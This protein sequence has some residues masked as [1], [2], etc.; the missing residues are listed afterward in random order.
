MSNDTSARQ[1][2]E[3][4]VLAMVILTCTNGFTTSGLT[5]YDSAI[6]DEFGGARA[7]LKL[8][9][10]VAFW[11][12][13]ALL[14]FIGVLI[15][16]VGARRTS[17]IGLA[18]LAVALFLYGLAQSYTHLYLLHALFAVA[19]GLSGSMAMIVL[20]SRLFSARRGL[21]IG[22]ALAG[23]SLGGIVMGQL[24]PVL[25]ETFGWRRSFQLEALVPL[26]LMVLV[27]W[28][29]PRGGGSVTAA[30]QQG[31]ISLAGLLRVPSFWALSTIGLITFGS[32]VG[33][34]QNLFLY[35]NRDLGLSP[36]TAGSGISV[37]LGIALITKFSAGWLC[38]HVSPRRLLQ[39][40][41]AV[42]AL[43]AA[44]MAS[45][46]AGLV[47]PAIALIGIGWGGVYTLT[48]YLIIESFG[49]ASAGRA[50]GATS[51]MESFGAGAGP[52]LVAAVFDGTGSYGPA[53]TGIAVLIS[54]AIL[55][56]LVV[57]PLP[58]T[59]AAA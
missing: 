2:W 36:A 39:A 23:T 31:G 25:L 44:G 17:L 26:F 42:M 27:W 15:D 48:N 33:V 35:L 19:L 30:Q 54:A 32:I 21:A 41:L 12:A 43:G 47:W 37:L 38:D 14:P 3:I 51:V 6:L 13:A 52:L 4:A 16:R 29:V 40:H 57:R 5:I 7:A 22:I 59:P 24:G 50:G 46:H 1:P 53:F 58:P 20:V 56:T 8:R 49:V 11:T 10:T 45:G 28:L 18:L 9:E 55:L 34:L